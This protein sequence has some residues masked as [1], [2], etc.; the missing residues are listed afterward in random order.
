[1]LGMQR[2]LFKEKVV[3]GM[4][5]EVKLVWVIRSPMPSLIM[6]LSVLVY[7][8]WRDRFLK[9]AV[10]WCEAPPSKGHDEGFIS[11][12]DSKMST[13]LPWCLWMQC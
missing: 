4:V 13:R 2:M 7:R 5:R 1:M 9:L 8:E 6:I 10:A 11:G 12:V 3:L